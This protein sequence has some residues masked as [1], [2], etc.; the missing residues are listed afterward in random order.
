MPTRSLSNSRLSLSPFTGGAAVLAALCL[1]TTP[2]AAAN[3]LDLPG[4][5]L[6]WQDEFDQASPDTSEWELFDLRD[7]FNQELQYYR[8]EQITTSN[9]NLVITATDEPL[10]FKPYR[11]GRMESW[12]EFGF[13]RFEARIQMPSGQGFWPAFWLL[14]ETDTTPWPTGG[15]IDILENRGSQPNLVSSAYHFP[16]NQPNTSQFRFDEYTISGP[17][18]FHNSFNTFAVEW[19]ADEMRFFVNGE[20]YHTL[21]DDQVPIFDTPKKIVLNLAVGGFF[22][23]NPDAST[24]FPAEML[25]DYVRVWER[26]P[27]EPPTGSVLVNG[28]FEDNGGSIGNWSSFGSNGS[29]V[30]PSDALSAD[31]GHAL[32]LYG[33]FN[34]Q[35]NASGITQSVA[36][37]P[38][39]SLSA[40][41]FAQTPSWDSIAGTSNEVVMKI[42]FYDQIGGVFGTNDFLGDVS[43]TLADG[44]SAEDVWLGQTLDAIAPEGAAEARLVFS[45][46]QPNN[47]AGA[48]WI[49]AASL[50]VGEL[51]I[52]GDYNGDGF[53]SQADLDL[54]LLNWGDST[55]PAG[56][57][58]ADQFDG[59]QISQNELDGVLLN[60]GDGTPPSVNAIPEPGVLGI[61]GTLGLGVGG[62][63]R[64]LR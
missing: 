43:I 3:P 39:A 6:I 19:E 24:P 22:G 40:A 26:A 35:F 32:K 61:V 30:S 49:D 8:P 7:S 38:G 42:E 56:W 1:S 28:S 37:T 55:L 36:I 57:A 33:Q 31:G 2:P 17:N 21:T 60:W 27:I 25:V 45:F 59:V 20:N 15:E 10:N 51:F 4:W 52:D 46:L 13:G 54:V 62:R 34:G 5:D 44:S 48:V 58:A 12:R 29:N 63:R 23:G 9:G 41:A 18:N 14:P 64:R 16:T 11:S 50:V 47:Q 53:V